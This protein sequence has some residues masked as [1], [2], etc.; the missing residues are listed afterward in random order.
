MMRMSIAA[1]ACLAGRRAV[2]EDDDD[3]DHPSTLL[4]SNLLHALNVLG[5]IVAMAKNKEKSR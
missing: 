3:V 5:F 2:G 1:S 4:C